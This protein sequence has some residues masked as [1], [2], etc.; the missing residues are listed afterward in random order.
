MSVHCRD[1]PTSHLIEDQR[2]GD[3]ICPECGIVVAERAIDV[4][5]EWRSFEDDRGG[6]DPSRVGA[7]QNPLLSGSDLSTSIATSFGGSDLERS[8]ANSQRKTMGSTDSQMIS[9]MQAIREISDRIN[10]SKSIQDRAAENYKRVLDSKQLH[11]KKTEVQAAACLYIAC[12]EE[13]APRTFKEICAASPV[14][15]KEI[16]RCYKPIVQCLQ[17]KLKMVSGAD[18]MPRFCGNLNLSHNVQMA[19]TGIAKQAEKLNL[20]A[21]RNPTTLAEAAIYMATEGSTEKRSAMEIGEIAGASETTIKEAYKLLRPHAAKLFPAELKFEKSM[22]AAQRMKAKQ[23]Q[24]QFK[25]QL[26]QVEH[27]FE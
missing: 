2:A 7:P 17:I 11:G 15:V 16:E 12:R 21:G 13:D 14:N 24:Q 20:L 22:R 5:T 1:H 6:K 19:A 25:S 23:V 27:K 3:L 8:L 4:S 18:Y 26:E 10:I 9:A